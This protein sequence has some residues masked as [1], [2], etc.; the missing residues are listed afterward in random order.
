MKFF[1]RFVT[2][3]AAVVLL[4]TFVPL[5][6]SSAGATG[7]WSSAE[8]APGTATLNAGGDAV[9][10]A[11]S[12]SSSGNCGVIG[13]YADAN[14]NYQGYVENEVGGRWQSAEEIPGLDALNV[15]DQVGDILEISCT[16]SGDCSA[17]GVFTDTNNDYQAF[18]V[19]ESNGTWGNAVQ[20]PGFSSTNGEG[21]GS[22]LLALSC[23]SPGNCSAGG[24]YVD[25]NNNLQAFVVN[26]T[27]GTWANA[28]EVPGTASLNFGNNAQLEFLQCKAP[29]ACDGAG[30][31]S[32]SN[33][34]ENTFVISEQG[35]TW[36]PAVALSANGLTAGDGAVVPATLSCSSVGNCAMGGA[37]GITSS[38]TGAFVANEIGGSWQ[39]A[40]TVN[41]S[42][43]TAGAQDT[44]L[45]NSISCASNGNCS[46]TGA[47]SPAQKQ[48]QV[49]VVSEI[50]GSWVGPQMIPGLATLNAGDL[51]L[52]VSISCAL[53]GDCTMGGVYSDA[54]NNDHSFI[55]DQVNGAWQTPI[56]VPGVDGLDTGQSA[57]VTAV[58]CS[59]DDSCS[60][61]GV[62][63]DSSMN[64][65]AF[66]D[67]S[68][69]A[70]SAPSAPV[71]IVTASGPGE[72]SGVI[73]VP[74]RN[75]GVPVTG[76]QYSLNG[77]AWKN[78]ALSPATVPRVRIR[79]LVAGKRYQVRVRA[80]NAVGDGASSSRTVV[81]E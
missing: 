53:P 72:I 80:V 60:L 55:V 63:T 23:S 18:V 2:C 51:A 28:V 1:Q 54:Q 13:Y 42:S 69:A 39:S 4:V 36:Q 49:F 75:G 31:Y 71:F 48:A 25:T 68:A 3:C 7:A 77:G 79:G 61:S 12:C 66:V 5:A 52:G 73:G 78:V 22:E 57:S 50:N 17:G 62:Y 58:V 70:F 24:Q 44:A 30:F 19:T 64:V 8:E 38:S 10:G 35:G 76:Y 46:A 47:I 20:I 34:Q 40:T 27:K 59:A 29:G 43:I 81:A 45:L 67:T 74:S 9:P 65:Q 14:N 15:G 33:S 32:G 37:Y 16:G 6:T 21:S 26:E 11:Q 56:E 41:V